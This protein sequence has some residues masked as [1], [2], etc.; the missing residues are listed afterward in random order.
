MPN[1]R[2]LGVHDAG[3]VEEVGDRADRRVADIVAVHVVDALEQ[4]DIHEQAGERAP[5]RGAGRRFRPLAEGTPVQ[6][7]RSGIRVGEADQRFLQARHPLRRA[8]ASIAT[9]PPVAA[10][11]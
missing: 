6:K 10:S 9:P 5:V 11:R 8:Q 2:R 3:L 4:V 1:S 7:G